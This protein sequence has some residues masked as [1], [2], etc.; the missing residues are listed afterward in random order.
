M[1]GCHF[2]KAFL[3]SA[4]ENPTASGGVTEI[5]LDTRTAR[6]TRP[7][8]HQL[9]LVSTELSLSS[10]S[11]REAHLTISHFRH[12]FTAIITVTRPIKPDCGGLQRPQGPRSGPPGPTSHPSPTP[13][14]SDSP[15]K[16]PNP[17]PSP[18]AR[19]LPISLCAARLA[20][21][22]NSPLEPLTYTPHLAYTKT[23]T[24]GPTA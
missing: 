20:G 18:R 13:A 19:L 12:S 4:Q 15:H 14:S 24:T 8:Y 2:A 16:P 3:I 5:V 21:R 1:P 6:S 7:Y 22:P 17:S 10:G 9:H 11:P 23:L